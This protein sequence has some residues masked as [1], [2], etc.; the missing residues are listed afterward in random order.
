MIP[1]LP[2]AHRTVTRAFRTVENSYFP[3]FMSKEDRM[4]MGRAIGML[5]RELNNMVRYVGPRHRDEIRN[6]ARIVENAKFAMFSENDV[7]AAY[8]KIQRAENQYNRIA[9]DIFRR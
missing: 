1:E 5:S 3:I 8:R 4:R 2:Q 6:V 7:R 9:D